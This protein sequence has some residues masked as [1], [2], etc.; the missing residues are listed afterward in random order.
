MATSDSAWSSAHTIW[1]SS[2]DGSGSGLDADLLDGQQGSYYAAASALSS[3][4]HTSGNTGLGA[5][6]KTTF[7]SGSGGA[8]FGANH[9]SM[10]VD[11]ANGSWSGPNY[12]DLIIGY[13][14]G[15]RIGAAYGG[16]KFYNNSP[17]TDTNNDGEGEGT[18]A[19]LMTVGGVNGG[20]GVKIQ[21]ALIIAGAGT[22]QTIDTTTHSLEIKNS[23][24]TGSGGLVLQGSDGTHGLQL[25]W[26]GSGA[27]YG[28]LDA[29]MGKLGYSKS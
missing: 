6:W 1:D 29:C 28:F 3:K 24:A 5:T 12:S 2:T 17:T 18:E 19:L 9:Y 14:T 26:D 23:G 16:T 10:G 25:Y 8:T 13:H 11:V 4:V 27:N 22:Q 20:S 21:N 15:I 7:Y